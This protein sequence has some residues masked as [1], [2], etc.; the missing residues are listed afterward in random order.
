MNE[1]YDSAF[2]V[3][4]FIFIEFCYYRLTKS[5]FTLYVD[6]KE[7]GKHFELHL[8]CIKSAIQIKSDRLIV[9]VCCHL[10]SEVSL[11]E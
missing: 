3:S 8:K 10:V 7:G 1:F 4:V 5:F 11:I 9:Q 2:S 6:G